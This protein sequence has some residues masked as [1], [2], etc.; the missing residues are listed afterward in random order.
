VIEQGHN[1]LPLP[2]W[3]CLIAIIAA[4]A[5]PVRAQKAQARLDVVDGAR[6]LYLRGAPWDRGYQ[7]GRL[8]ADDIKLSISRYLNVGIAE[9][10]GVPRA[11]LKA[12]A[13]Q[14]EP[15]IPDEVKQEMRGIA[16]GAGVD[17]EDVLILNT[18]VDAV[19]HGVPAS[20][21]AKQAARC[22]GI[23]VMGH[24]TSDGRVLHGHN[25]DWTTE[26][27]VQKTAVLLVIAPE[28]GVP[29][30]MPTHA[31]MVACNAGMNA[32]GI[33][34]S[35]MTSESSDQRL[36]GMPLMIMARMLLEKARSLDQALSLLREWPDTCGWNMIITD[37]KARDLR[38]VEISATHLKIFK[39]GDRAENT[40]TGAPIAQAVVRTNHFVDPEMLALAARRFG[41]TTEQGIVRAI[42]DDS[43]RRYM[44]LEQRLRADKLPVGP[45]DIQ[46]WLHQPPVGNPGNIQSMVFDPSNQE[47][48]TANAAADG[49]PACDTRY[50]RVSLRPY[51]GRGM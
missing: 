17:Y 23:A 2:L 19:V 51:F 3:L 7:Y 45:A 43:Y 18:H 47:I 20:E 1:R 12:A 46:A 22:S 41:L 48:W 31:G 24:W 28:D 50:S 27:E 13:A 6:V 30:C 5:A 25:V 4:T 42:T 16:A 37:G 44:A 10:W 39:P 40:P 26:E 14:M 29:F 9:H 8:L 15:F 33:T 21:Q 32:A 35:D 38:A 49:T 34:Y 36:N 11:F